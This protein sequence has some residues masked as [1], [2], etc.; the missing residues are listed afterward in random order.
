MNL[1]VGLSQKSIGTERYSLACF[2]GRIR[3]VEGD[4]VGC[5]RRLDC[6]LSERSLEFLR[7]V[8]MSGN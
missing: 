4:L 5:W 8:T 6:L 2:E 1:T 7:R 3:E